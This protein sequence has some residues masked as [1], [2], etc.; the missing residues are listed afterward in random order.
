MRQDEQVSRYEVNRNVRM[1]ITRHDADLTRIDYS[2]MGSTI[3][4]NG[5]L[6]RPNRD[7]TA[8]EIENIAKELSALPRVRSIQFDLNNWLVDAS[9]D[10]WQISR[11]KKTAGPRETAHQTA[12]SDDTTVII[13]KEE[14]L[15]DV[16]DDIEKT[17]KSK[18]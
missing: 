12:V 9:G 17:L 2:F 10:S 3:Y 1:V 16:I 7:F 13:E 15:Q 14:G 11:V 8:Q 18:D 4:L 6:V 5:D